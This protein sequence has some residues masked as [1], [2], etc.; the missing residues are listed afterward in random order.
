MHH[1]SLNAGTVQNRGPSPSKGCALTLFP[2]H[3]FHRLQVLLSELS[4]ETEVQETPSY[5]DPPPQPGLQ[6][7][8][9]RDSLNPGDI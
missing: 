2:P 6:L 5:R 9:A 3:T 4:L 8:G 1:I 7:P